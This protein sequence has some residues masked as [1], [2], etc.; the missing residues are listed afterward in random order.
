M[1]FSISDMKLSVRQNGA[2]PQWYAMMAG[3]REFFHPAL[4]AGPDRSKVPP[5]GGIARC[6]GF[7]TLSSVWDVVGGD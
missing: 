2:G 5:G 1:Y 4:L 6:D 3:A 7:R